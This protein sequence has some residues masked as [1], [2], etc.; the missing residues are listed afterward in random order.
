MAE[1]GYRT[2]GEGEKGDASLPLP[3]L[4]AALPPKL[5]YVSSPGGSFSLVY[6]FMQKVPLETAPSGGDI[7][8]NGLA[9]FT[10]MAV[11]VAGAEL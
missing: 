10:A 9:S 8:W 6:F 5:Q 4:P 7:L 11:A 2:G 1:P 3:H